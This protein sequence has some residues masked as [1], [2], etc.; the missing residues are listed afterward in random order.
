MR[1]ILKYGRASITIRG[2]PCSRSIRPSSVG[3]IWGCISAKVGR[4]FL[5]SRILHR[6][7]GYNTET[8]RG[9]L[10]EI[11]EPFLFK[12]LPGVGCGLRARSDKHGELATNGS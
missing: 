1:L 11:V 8:Q 5:L 9:L 12:G 2:S 10:D 7:D 3:G 6:L 4:S